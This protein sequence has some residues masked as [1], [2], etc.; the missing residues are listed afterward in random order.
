[1]I[2]LLRHGQT[3]WNKM[4][5]MQ[6]QTDIPLNQTGRDSA[7]SCVQDILKAGVTRIISSDLMRAKQTAEIIN[8][9]L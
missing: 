3:D 6:G 2:Y 8:S 4:G 5:R 1:M 7:Y 9:C